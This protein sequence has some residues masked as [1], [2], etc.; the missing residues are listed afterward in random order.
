MLFRSFLPRG[1]WSKVLLDVPCSNT[2]VLNRRPEARH[3]LTRDALKTLMRTQDELLEIGLSLVEKNPAGGRVVYST[4]SILAC[5][6]EERVEAALKRHP[7]AHVSLKERKLPETPA[8]DGGSLFVIDV[9]AT[10]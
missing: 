1:P 9:G 7:R 5:E 3:A 4:C 8:D 2:A 6:G 10:A